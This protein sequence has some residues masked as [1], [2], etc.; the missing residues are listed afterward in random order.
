VTIASG[1]QTADITVN[2][3]E[4]AVVEADEDF[5]VTLDS[6]STANAT[7]TGANPATGTITNDDK[8]GISIDDPSAEEGSQVSFTITLDAAR[9][10]DVDSKA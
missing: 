2:T 5:T 10:M 1:S 4:D 7:I 8:Y 6:V 3:T 9:S